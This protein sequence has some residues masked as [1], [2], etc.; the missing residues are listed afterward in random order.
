MRKESA[1]AGIDIIIAI[2][3][4]I[5]F[6]GLIISL[7]Y[8]NVIENV[9]LKKSTMAMIHLTEIS[10]NIGIQ[11]YDAEVYNII[12]TEYTEILEE[13][14]LVPQE[15]IDSYKVEMAVITELE[16]TTNYEDI[17][18]KIKIKLTYELENKTYTCSIERMKIRE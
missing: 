7:I 17:I 2:I 15:V 14:I 13:N 5:I 18:K 4:I 10:E 6:S 12:G 16:D 8:N 3:A 9:K 11:D 1:L